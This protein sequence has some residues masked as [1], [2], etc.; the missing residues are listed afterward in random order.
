MT[1]ENWLE[2]IDATAVDKAVQAGE[3]LPRLPLPEVE[4]GNASSKETLYVKFLTNPHKKTSSNFLKGYAFVAEMDHQGAKKQMFVPDSLRFN[5]A[6]ECRLH[7]VTEPK[8][9]Y[10]VIGA[11]IEDMKASKNRPAMKGVKLY[12]CQLKDREESEHP[13]PE[14]AAA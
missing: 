2:G 3:I 1:E 9:H 11:S 6:K 10:F 12:W 5:L 8:D 4:P 13:L 14:E 7:N